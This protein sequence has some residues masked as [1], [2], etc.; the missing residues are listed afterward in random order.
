MAWH[1][2][3]R[4]FDPDILHVDNQLLVFIKIQAI[5]FTKTLLKPTLS[6]KLP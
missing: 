2:R 3:G 4:R 6:V 5:F 1:A